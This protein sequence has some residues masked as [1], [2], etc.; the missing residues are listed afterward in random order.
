MNRRFDCAAG[1][2]SSAGKQ[3]S[4]FPH[5]DRRDGQAAM[6]AGSADLRSGRAGKTFGILNGPNQNVGIQ[7]YHRED[8][9]ASG[10]I[11]DSISPTT[12][13]TPLSLPMNSRSGSSAGTHLATGFPRLVITS[14]SRVLRTSSIRVRH[15]ALNSAAATFFMEK[16]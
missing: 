2:D 14:G 3:P 12:R 1:L 15:R 13:I 6:T 9:H 8:S 16:L 5:S 11:G 10:S 4:E 7:Q